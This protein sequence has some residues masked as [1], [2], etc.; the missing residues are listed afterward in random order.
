[1]HGR[2]NIKKAKALSERGKRMA[3]SR[4]KSDRERRDAEEPA[5]LR[6]S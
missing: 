3:E 1:M 6:E 5:R 2:Y 4:W